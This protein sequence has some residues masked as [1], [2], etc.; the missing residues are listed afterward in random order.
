[1][2][3]VIRAALAKIER[4]TYCAECIRCR[5][6]DGL[7][8]PGEVF[9]DIR[10]FN[11]SPDLANS[12]DGWTGGFPC[13]VRVTASCIRVASCSGFFH[14]FV[15]ASFTDSNTH[16]VTVSCVWVYPAQGISGAGHGLG[17]DDDRSMLVR[18]L[19]K[20]FDKTSAC[21]SGI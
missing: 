3:D 20:C 19:L 13:Q 6:A 8:S 2:C 1:M 14:K 17:V 15:Q 12:V 18:D 9:G 21:S 11:P 10:D 5:I 7:A 4:D 16:S